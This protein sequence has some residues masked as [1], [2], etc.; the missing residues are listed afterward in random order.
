MG[1]G[2]QIQ[3]AQTI[4]DIDKNPFSVVKPQHKTAAKVQLK[5]PNILNPV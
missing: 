1:Q 5:R 4:D 3:K 2:S